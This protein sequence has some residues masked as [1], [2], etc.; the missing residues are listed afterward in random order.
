[1][2]LNTEIYGRFR[3]ENASLINNQIN[4]SG[5]YSEEFSRLPAL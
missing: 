5:Q 1:M 4:P 3:E 2:H